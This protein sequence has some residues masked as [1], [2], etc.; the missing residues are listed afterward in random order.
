MLWCDG[1]L[2]SL[3]M[4]AQVT[5]NLTQEFIRIRSNHEED[6]EAIVAALCL[7]TF[8]NRVLVR[9][10]IYHRRVF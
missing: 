8:K 3:H 5:S 4:C 7:R 6:R 2:P 10:G 1:F 9:H